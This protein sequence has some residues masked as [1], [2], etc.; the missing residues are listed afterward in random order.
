LVNDAWPRAAARLADFSPRDH[1][2]RAL[3]L[4]CLL[5]GLGILALAILYL[6]GETG[7]LEQGLPDLPSFLWREPWMPLATPPRLGIAHAWVS[8]L[9]TV[10]TSLAIAIPLGFGIGLFAAETAPE[11]LRRVLQPALELLAGIPAVV[12]GFFGYVTLVKLFERWFALPTGESLLTASLILA[13]MVLPFIA[14]TSAEAF[15][16][17]FREYREA[18]LAL[19]VTRGYLVRRIIRVKALPG[20]LAAVALGL[21]RGLGETLAVLMLSGN[22]AAVPGRLLDRG[23]PITALLATEL[24]ETVVHS[25]KY[26]ILFTA[27]FLLMLAVLAVNLL[28]LFLKRRLFRKIHGS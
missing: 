5:L 27:G 28:I 2:L 9:L 7:I 19:G 15:G 16:A 22:S 11:T 18:G 17:V 20:L 8:T 4:A 10:G 14:S 25:H 21:A 3:A 24:G 13:V 6:A 23:Q 1:A 26:R 12:Y